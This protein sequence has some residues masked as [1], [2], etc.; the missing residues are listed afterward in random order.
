MSAETLTA[1]AGALDV[2][3]PSLS[4][5]PRDLW[6]GMLGVDPDEVTPELIATKTDDLKGKYVTVRLDVVECS[7]DLR[8][9]F[10]AEAIH[11]ECIPKDDGIQDVAAE[12]N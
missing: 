7:A 4:R 6:A 12:L 1:I 2:D 9:A 8:P 10:E 11:F 3:L 5:E